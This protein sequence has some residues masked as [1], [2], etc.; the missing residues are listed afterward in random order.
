[1]LEI[2]LDCVIGCKKSWVPVYSK[3]ARK[4]A[5]PINFLLLYSIIWNNDYID[6]IR[7]QFSLNNSFWVFWIYICD[8]SRGEHQIQCTSERDK[9]TND[10]RDLSVWKWLRSNYFTIFSSIH[11]FSVYY[12]SCGT[13]PGAHWE[14]AWKESPVCFA[15]EA[16][17]TRECTRGAVSSIRTGRNRK[18][19]NWLGIALAHTKATCRQTSLSSGTAGLRMRLKT[20]FRITSL[21]IYP[22]SVDIEA[23]LLSVSVQLRCA[24]RRADYMLHGFRLKEKSRISSLKSGRLGTCCLTLPF[25]ENFN[26]LHKKLHR[27]IFYKKAFLWNLAFY[28]FYREKRK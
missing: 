17:S 13:K 1:M 12:S 22:R 14:R 25:L 20:Y 26:L 11:L 19:M 6:H 27:T 7:F 3:R 5:F 9:K 18:L 10:T 2:S 21:T 15:I 24:C 23:T 16:E 28:S 4:L 8:V